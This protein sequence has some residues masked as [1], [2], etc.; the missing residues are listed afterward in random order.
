MYVARSSLAVYRLPLLHCALPPPPPRP[1]SL[2][3]SLGC[4]KRFVTQG[5]K[6]TLV[7]PSTKRTH[8]QTDA[9]IDTHPPTTRALVADE[10]QTP[11][12][13]LPCILQAA[14][15]AGAHGAFLSGAGSSIMAITSGVCVCV[16]AIVVP[17]E[18]GCC[19]CVFPLPFAT[20]F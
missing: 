13:S 16:R 17:V 9:R 7:Y 6:N 10:I 12:R 15:E 2:P 8:A 20:L 14:L 5:M 4:D 19:V 3:L 11:V 18:E 1:P